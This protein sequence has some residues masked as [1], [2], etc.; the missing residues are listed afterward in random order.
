MSASPLPRALSAP[1]GEAHAQ[2]FRALQE[3]L[4]KSVSSVLS[5]GADLSSAR[6]QGRSPGCSSESSGDSLL[7]LSL[8]A[9]DELL[10]GGLPRGVLVEITGR[11]SSGRFTL[12]LHALASATQSGE[13]AALVDLGDHLDPQSA[14]DQGV[15]LERLLWLRPRVLKDA[16]TSAETV[17][18]AG[19]AFVVLDLGLK[20]AK[21]SLSR[22][23]LDG[24]WLRLA[25]AAERQ[26][27]G[28]LVCSPYRISGAAAGLV[29]GAECARPRWKGEAA[30]PALLT[31]LSSRLT[32]EKQ[33]GRRPGETS[34]L[35]L[36]AKD[37]LLFESPA[38]AR[39]A[40][41]RNDTP[42]Q[43][44]GVSASASLSR[45]LKMGRG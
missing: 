10:Q 15:V 43:T 41:D 34:L 38:A 19:F 2:A 25:R 4:P 30:G 8:R 1:G 36:T 24:A 32:L 7:P 11:R 37:A 20:I 6:P 29:V 35:T 23:R 33:R 28:L 14:L 31:G 17:I 9:V 13:S 40:R 44:I 26:R 22:T 39:G 27:T 45:G 5:R 42:A 18:A 3:S 12:L 16:L 21:G